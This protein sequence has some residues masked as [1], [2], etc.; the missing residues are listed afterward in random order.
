MDYKRIYAEFIKA[1]RE[2]EPSLSGYT[3]RHH[4]IPRCMG[5]GDEPANLIRLTA[6]DHFFAHLLLAKAHGGPL[7]YAVNALIRGSSIGG[8]RDDLSFALRGRRWYER[9]KIEFSAAHS[10]R[11]KGRFTGE[12]H[13]MYGKP[14]S[15][16]ALEKLNARLAS[17]YNPMQS[18]E[19]REKVSKALKGRVYSAETIQRMS[20]ARM[21]KPL[22]LAVRAN[23]SAGHKGKKLSAATIAKIVALN[24][25]KRR[26]PEQVEAMRQRLTGRK[27]SPEH[28]EKLRPHLAK[29]SRFRGKSHSAESRK[30]MAAVCAARRVYVAKHGGN[31]RKV[32]LQMMRVAGIEI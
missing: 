19:A 13:P 30:R 21:G 12:A 32:T 28:V 26:T 1:R 6:G 23:M 25:G 7:W 10:K 31:A 18:P 3:E 15:P 16:V 2:R 4:I 8:R 14:C 17:G 5:G 29:L 11:M 9:T 24:T 27:L 20:S 22:S